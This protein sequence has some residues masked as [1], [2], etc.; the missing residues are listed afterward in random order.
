MAK[1]SQK[2]LLGEGI[3]GLIGKGLKKG[4]QAVG[5]VGGALKAATDSGIDAGV[6][7]L[8]K[9]GKAGYEKTED[10]LTSRNEKLLKVLDSD[11][12]MVA[13][14]KKIKYSTNK[15]IAIVNVIPYDFADDGDIK[16]DENLKLGDKIPAKNEKSKVVKYR[17]KDGNW[18][19]ITG[20]FKSKEEDDPLTGGIKESPISD[21][22][23]NRILKL[24]KG[25]V[26]KL[27]AAAESSYKALRR[28]A[29]DGYKT[30]RYA[31]NEIVGAANGFLTAIDEFQQGY[32]E[33][34]KEVEP[35][36]KFKPKVGDEVLVRTKKV[37]TGEPGVVRRLNP[38]GRITIATAGN[39]AGYAFD[40]KNVLPSPRVKNEKSSQIDLLRQL[41]LI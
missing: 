5:A 35:E 10:L 25:G 37:P 23:T 18:D 12:V 7:D 17:F 8:I 40:P 30:G 31:A 4:A 13:P 36:V 16:D 26:E 14:D 28:L 6:G 1:L 24:L 32:D 9:G 38:N 41:T 20:V 34:S 15:K 22:K 21:D 39:K 29:I 2:E 3:T 19:K 11:G 33:G 27:P